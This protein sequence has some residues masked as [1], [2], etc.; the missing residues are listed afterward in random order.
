MPSD[1][2][3]R[4][5]ALAVKMAWKDSQLW[6]IADALE[7]SKNKP[8]AARSGLSKDVAESVSCPICLSI[9]V[10]PRLLVSPTCVC[11]TF[12][13][14]SCIETQISRG[15]RKCPTCR[16]SIES[17]R[18]HVQN[19]NF[20]D[21]LTYACPKGCSNFHGNMSDLIRHLHEVHDAMDKKKFVMQVL[22]EYVVTVEEQTKV[23]K[24]QVSAFD[25]KEKMYKMQLEHLQT[26]FAGLPN[27]ED[28]GTAFATLQ[29][30]LCGF[31]S[32][33]PGACHQDEPVIQVYPTQY[34]RALKAAA[35]DRSPSLDPNL[36]ASSL[37]VK[38]MLGE[39][40]NGTPLL[41]MEFKM[42]SI[43]NE[44]L[45]LERKESEKNEDTHAMKLVA[46]RDMVATMVYHNKTVSI[47]H[48]KV[49]RQGRDL[50]NYE[51][52]IL[53]TWKD[54]F[55]TDLSKLRGT[56]APARSHDSVPSSSRSDRTTARRETRS[57]SPRHIL[58]SHGSDGER[59]TRRVRSDRIRR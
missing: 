41:G 32:V 49:W 31:L 7:A 44:Y 51:K 35:S 47:T 30:L 14:K 18:G 17:V 26:K 34:V 25:A 59:S 23:L 13:C 2:L 22:T 37:R 12:F 38:A 48:Q 28:L 3:K 45:E 27:A 33:Q 36:A 56:P 42:T 10:A 16:G 6:T 9:A 11:P 8:E 21:K 58:T 54:I 5:A 24:H 15:N 1:T 39:D 50:V 55:E 57:R 52:N 53:F 20:I 43:W 19:Q 40:L 29:S 4:S 46:L